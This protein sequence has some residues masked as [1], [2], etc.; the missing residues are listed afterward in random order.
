MTQ[1]ID[2]SFWSYFAALAGACVGVLFSW[3]FPVVKNRAEG[4]AQLGAAIALTICV[5]PISI[6]AVARWAAVGSESIPDLSAAV[7][8]SIGLVSV[9]VAKGWMAFAD[10]KSAAIQEQGLDALWQ[11]KPTDKP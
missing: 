11:N 7:G 9:G 3:C 10:R 2:L 4:L 6:R 5:S 1:V 8:A